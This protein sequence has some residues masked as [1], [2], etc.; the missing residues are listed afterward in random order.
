MSSVALGYTNAEILTSISVYAFAAIRLLPGISQIVVNINEINFSIPPVNKIFSDLE[1]INSNSTNHDIDL[2][3]V[4]TSPSSKE[5]SFLEINK[6]SFK[7]KNSQSNILE[8]INLKINENDFIGIIGA[9][10]IGKSSLIDIISGLLKPTNGKINIFDKNQNK[11]NPDSLI[12][13][14]PQEPIILD[15]TLE[16]NIAL[17]RDIKNK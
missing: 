9:S 15:E 16:N 13:Y 2:L 1:E 17:T 6:L 4:N 3:N 7:Y 14:L 10:G 5:F 8:N 12:S 11:I